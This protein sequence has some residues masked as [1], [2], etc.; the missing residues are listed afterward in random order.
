MQHIPGVDM[1]IR[2]PW[3]RAFPQQSAWH[4]AG[5][6]YREDYRVYTLLGDG[7]IQEGQVWEASMLAGTQ[8]AGQPRS[9]RG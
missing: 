2:F 9:D 6:M 5:K 1:S 8:K 7:E 4:S 3:D